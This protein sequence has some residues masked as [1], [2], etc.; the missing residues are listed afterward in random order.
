MHSVKLRI[1][2]TIL[3][4]RSKRNLN[5]DSDLTSADVASSTNSLGHRQSGGSD[6]SGNITLSP[7]A[8]NINHSEAQH[9]QT[10]M[11][12]PLLDETQFYNDALVQALFEDP[13]LLS[14]ALQSP[15]LKSL[16]KLHMR[17]LFVTIYCSILQ[18]SF[19]AYTP[20][21]EGDSSVVVVVF[22]ARLFM[23]LFG[24]PLAL[25]PRPGCFKTIEWL[26]FWS[27]LRAGMM[28]FYF[29]YIA[30][31]EGDFF[32]NDWFIIIFQVFYLQC[33]DALS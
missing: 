13:K 22:Y 7:Y 4:R 1:H 25:L 15:E 2:N 3:D 33:A 5:K 26:F 23:D 24:R 16:L 8:E 9:Q 29:A 18:G 20:S 21:S 14:E 6:F 17:T 19:L 32:R 11:R 12:N 28:V 30:L 31:P 27:I 10:S